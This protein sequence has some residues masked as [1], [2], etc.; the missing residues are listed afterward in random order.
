MGGLTREL[1]VPLPSIVRLIIYVSGPIDGKIV[2][3]KLSQ[4]RATRAIKG[5]RLMG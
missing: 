2:I 4:K 3:V 1:R 5:E